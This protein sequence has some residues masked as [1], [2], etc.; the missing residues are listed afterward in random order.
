MAMAFHQW[1]VIF[2]GR[3]IILALNMGDFDSLFIRPVTMPRPILTCGR[4]LPKQIAQRPAMHRDRRDDPDRTCDR[5]PVD[6]GPD[7][8]RVR[9]PRTP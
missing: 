3:S 6:Y 5:N 2:H 9:T 1:Q 7:G 8:T 4:L